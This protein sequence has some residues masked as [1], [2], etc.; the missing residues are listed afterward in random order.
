MKHFICTK[1]DKRAAFAIDR[2]IN[3]YRIKNNRPEYVGK[4]KFNTGSSYG[5]ESEVYG[6]LVELK[7]VPRK[8]FMANNKYYS[9]TKT[10]QMGFTLHMI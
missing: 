6:L 9:W 4:V 8:P 7:A 3:I 10:K 2:T 1:K 5:D